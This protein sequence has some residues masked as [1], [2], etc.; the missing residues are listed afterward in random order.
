M[1]FVSTLNLLRPTLPSY[2]HLTK[3]GL[4]QC[5]RDNFSL[6]VNPKSPLLAREMATTMFAM[7][8]SSVIE[9]YTMSRMLAEGPKVFT[10]DALTCEALENFDLSVSCA[11]YQQPFP[12]VVIELP[13]DYSQK[14]VVPFERGQHAPDFA[15]VHH[16]PKGQVVM[17]I[18]RMSSH[19][20]LTRLLK[21]DL[22]PTLE[23]VWAMAKRSWG[24]ED[25]LQM[26]PEESD[27]GTAICKLALNVCLMGT[28]YGVKCLGPDNPSYH[29]RLEKHAKLARK[30]GREKVEAADID[31]LT[32]PMQYVFAEEVVVF[33]REGGETS[34]GGAGRLDREASLETRPL[35]APALWPRPLRKKADRHPIRTGQQP[36]DDSRLDLKSLPTD[37]Y[38]AFVAV[39]AEELPSEAFAGNGTLKTATKTIDHQ[40]AGTGQ[41]L[42]VGDGLVEGLLPGMPLLLLAGGLAGGVNQ[43][44]LVPGSI[45]PPC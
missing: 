29:R 9:G 23:E 21:L 36:P 32:H 10:F 4:I 2:V 11:D 13:R 39:T 15:V 1:S 17:L 12:S 37:G 26:T 18:V 8:A 28:A 7:G 40:I 33:Q 42:D 6:N 43:L 31:L 24:P 34:G 45:I 5:Q 41:V 20:V 25:S 3:H 38:H 35:A 16:D 22:A 14:R 30:K 19:Q 44:G 27:L